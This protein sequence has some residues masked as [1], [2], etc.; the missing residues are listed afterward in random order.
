[1]KKK[2]LSVGLATAKEVART[3]AGDCTE[4][5]VLAAALGRAAGIPTKVA[6][7]L[8]YFQGM[9]GYHM[10]TEFYAAHGGAR[11]MPPSASA[12]ATP[13][14]SSWARPA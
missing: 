7:G 2:N 12:P 10:W 14:T 8:V 11:S 4:H 9:L 13:P 1:M 6:T 5:A 3:L